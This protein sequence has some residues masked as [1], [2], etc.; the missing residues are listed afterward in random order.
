MLGSL[1]LV[2]QFFN[3]TTQCEH[4]VDYLSQPATCRDAAIMLI[5]LLIMLFRNAQNFVRLCSGCSIISYMRTED[6]PS[7][8]ASWWC[9]YVRGGAFSLSK[10]ETVNE[11]LTP[12]CTWHVELLAYVEIVFIASHSQSGSPL[13]W[14]Y[15][16]TKLCQLQ[17]SNFRQKKLHLPIIARKFFL[18]QLQPSN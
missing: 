8:H 9:Q 15:G 17:P 7:F 13:V 1:S 12:T 5:F 18:R 11:S 14:V 2:F 16:C 4:H 6:W 10:N 3:R